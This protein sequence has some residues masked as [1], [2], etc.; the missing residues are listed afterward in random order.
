MATAPAEAVGRGLEGH[1]RR[2]V[3]EQGAAAAAAASQAPV[4]AEAGPAAACPQGDHCQD[5]GWSNCCPLLQAFRPMLRKAPYALIVLASSSIAILLVL[6]V[7]HLALP[8]FHWLSAC[9]KG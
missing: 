8:W 2:H 5:P 3:L 6:A 4:L 9:C 7:L 1:R